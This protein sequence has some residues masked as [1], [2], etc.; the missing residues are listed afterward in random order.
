MKISYSKQ[1][2]DNDDISAVVDVLKSNFLT[3][4][5]KINE[6]EKNISDYCDVPYACVVSSAT[7]ALH[8]SCLALDIG[9]G[10]IVW[11]S[12]NSF[13]ASANCVLYCNATID[14][15]D[16]D[17][18]TFNICPIKLEEKLLEYKKLG[19]KL[20]KAVIVVHFAGLSCD[21]KAI[22]KIA[23]QYGF[24]IIED[25]SHA[26]GG[27]YNGKKIGCCDFSDIA[28][29]SFHPVKMITTG[30]GGVILTKNNKIA[31]KAILLRSHGIVRSQEIEDINGGWYYEQ[32]LLGYNF[33]MTDLQAALGIS[34]LKK[35]DLFVK[36]RNELAKNYHQLL[37]GTDIKY[38]LIKNNY[39]SSYHL[40][41]VQ[42]E[43]RDK[44]YEYLKKHGIYTQIHYIPI[45]KQPYYQRFNLEN[46]FTNTDNYYKKTLSLPL[47][48]EL[49]YEEQI[50]IIN[51]ILKF[52]N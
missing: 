48:Y 4:G 40:F 50:N 38:Q 39:F 6:F 27:E 2:I 5:P 7:A 31:D 1:Y 16:I 20:P 24:F 30:E 43:N 34:Q 26:F 44:I 21:M 19:K 37:S 28:I 36:K 14:F 12:A 45:Y 18:K 22:R 9:Y 15:V 8:L 32:Q 47:Y 13:V 46:N 17:E 33:R 10:D 23:N 3:N 25:A 51:L 49:N 11:T 52:R 35:L 29:F 42:I 41:V